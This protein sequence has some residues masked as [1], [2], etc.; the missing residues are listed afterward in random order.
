[1]KNN[2]TEVYDDFGKN[3]SDIISKSGYLINGKPIDI[4]VFN[5]WFS[6]VTKHLSV[7]SN[8]CILDVG[9]GSGIFLSYFGKITKK[10]YGADIALS[11]VNSAKTIAQEITLQNADAK[12]VKFDNVY[13]DIVFCNGVFLLFESLKYAQEVLDHF[14]SISK[15]NAQIWIGDIP[16]LYSGL[17]ENFRRKGKSMGLELQHYPVSFFDDYCLKNNLKGER[18]EQS[19]KEGEHINNRYDYLITKK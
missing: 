17:D 3:F 6:H 14:L 12:S 18:I 2:W 13:F 4:D 10:L 9:C 19:F 8:S 11:Q 16:D 7:D 1:M 5:K 15:P